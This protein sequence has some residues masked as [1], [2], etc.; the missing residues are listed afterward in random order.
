MQP[1]SFKYGGQYLAL[2]L[3][4]ANLPGCAPQNKSSVSSSYSEPVQYLCENDLRLSVLFSPEQ[5]L[6]S[7]FPNEQTIQLNRVFV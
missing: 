2:G 3:V 4:L 6:V 7:I 1:K 5:A